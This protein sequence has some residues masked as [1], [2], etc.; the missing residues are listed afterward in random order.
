ME[1]SKNTETKS[2]KKENPQVKK[3]K[4]IL[5]GI[6]LLISLG[7]ASGFVIWVLFSNL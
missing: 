2:S 4:N 6:G 3:R 7:I 5:N 1:E